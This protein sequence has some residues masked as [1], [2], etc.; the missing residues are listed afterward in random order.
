MESVSGLVGSASL[1]LAVEASS[2]GFVAIR[3]SSFLHS[4]PA[5]LVAKSGQHSC[6]I[7]LLLAAP[8]AR[9][10]GERDHRRWNVE[11]HGLLDGPATFS[12]VLHPAAD[13]AEVFTV[14]L[15]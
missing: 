10:Q 13:V 11:I 12:R 6:R 8:E 9:Q 2:F 15:E 4:V 5:E 14:L 3:R 1:A 7:A